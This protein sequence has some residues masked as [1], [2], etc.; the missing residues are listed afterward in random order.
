MSA[1]NQQLLDAYGRDAAATAPPLLEEYDEIIDRAVNRANA[2]PQNTRTCVWMPNDPP[3]LD[4]SVAEHAELI[5][6]IAVIASFEAP[7]PDAAAV[8]VPPW[9]LADGTCVNEATS[10]LLDS[11]TPP[12]VSTATL[13]RDQSACAAPHR[14]STST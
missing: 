9:L 14:A 8:P 2:A 5:A 4:M 10:E 3:T 13:A 11:M 6:Y 7:R 12:R 1:A